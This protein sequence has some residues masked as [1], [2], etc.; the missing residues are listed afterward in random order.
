VQNTWNLYGFSCLA[1]NQTRKNIPFFFAVIS[2][3]IYN[4]C[5]EKLGWLPEIIQ[6]AS[7]ALKNEGTERL[8]ALAPSSGSKLWLQALA[9]SSGSNKRQILGTSMVFHA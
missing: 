1:Y 6:A 7:L 9:P 5:V 8:Q 3:A 4:N 2:F